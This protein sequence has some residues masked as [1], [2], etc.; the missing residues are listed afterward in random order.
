[1]EDGSPLL[2]MTVRPDDRVH[3]GLRIGREAL[4]RDVFLDK[5]PGCAGGPIRTPTVECRLA[6]INGQYPIW[7]DG[8][9]LNVR[10]HSG[11][12]AVMEGA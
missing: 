4:G 3:Y 9:L 2:K 10:K 5:P 12:H 8:L 1:M 11:Y 7:A 6:G